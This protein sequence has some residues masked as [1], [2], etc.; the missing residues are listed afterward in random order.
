MAPEPRNRHVVLER[1][2]LAQLA[3]VL[4][5]DLL[6]LVGGDRGIESIGAAGASGR[7][8]R[9]STAR[10][11]PRRWRAAAARACAGRRAGGRRLRRRAGRPRWRRRSRRRGRWPRPSGPR[12]R[13]QR[14]RSG[15]RGCRAE[16]WRARHRRDVA[17]VGGAAGPSQ[18][19]GRA[20]GA[21]Q[22]RFRPERGRGPRRHEGGGLVLGEGLVRNRHQAVVR[23][24]HGLIQPLPHLGVGRLQRRPPCAGWAAPSGRAASA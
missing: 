1:V 18:A 10:I 15:P 21:H 5:G 20:T 4:L 22:R 3:L 8:P 23:L 12:P 13:P 14:R 19:S 6:R 16:T 17:G 24:R 2:L 7:S 9:R 11:R